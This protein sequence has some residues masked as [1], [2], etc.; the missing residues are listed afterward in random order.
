MKLLE[1][2]GLTTTFATQSG[3]LRAVDGLSFSV[4]RG[5]TV[6]LV[7]ESGSGKSVTVLS[8][9]RLLDET[10]AT[11]SGRASFEGDDLVTMSE[12]QLREV[13]GGKIGMIFQEPMTALNPVLTVGSQVAET[14][15]LHGKVSRGEANRRAVEMLTLVGIPDPARRAREYPHQLSGGMR[16]RVMIA[17]ALAGQ[18]QLL[19]ADEPTTALDVTVQAQILDLMRRL[20]AEFGSAI[21]LITHDLGVVAEMADRVIIMYAG[22]KVEEASTVELFRNPR[23][24]YTKGLLGAVPRLGSSL[25]SAK[26][27]QR[28]AE[29][30]GTVPDLRIPIPGC[31]FAPRCPAAAPQ[32]L[33]DRPLVRTIAPGH[34]VACHFAEEAVPA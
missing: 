31:P 12:A 24:P 29:V 33:V 20:R 11:Q 15:R 22:R 25:N 1:V 8:L 10:M 16:Q 21:V 32:C 17:M 7:G 30:P 5:E 19:V 4:E 3:T 28:L 14:V 26:G 34:V 27:R 2:E 9:L 18:P 13:R 6:A 23:H